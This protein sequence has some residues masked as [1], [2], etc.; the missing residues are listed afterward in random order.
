MV[1]TI[2]ENIIPVLFTVLTPVLLVIVH[3]L[4][5][6]VAKKWDLQVA[7][8]YEDKID[9]M[10]LKGVKA[11][12]QKSINAVK[13]GKEK[14]SGEEKLDM[15]MKFV[16]AQLAAHKLPEK[17]SSELAMLVEAKIFDEKTKTTPTLVAE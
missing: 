1:S 16:N 3:G 17:A 5:R 2:L 6:K 9:D 11:A 10:I 14:T 8:V 7:L 15:V 13:S 4:L 12:Q